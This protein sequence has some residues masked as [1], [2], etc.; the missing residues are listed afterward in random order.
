MYNQEIINIGINLSFRSWT[1]IYIY[2]LYEFMNKIVF[3]PT[4]KKTQTLKGKKKKK[5]KK[6]KNTYSTKNL[7][8][9]AWR[10]WR[11]CLKIRIN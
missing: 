4:I 7:S 10:C 1:L 2:M 8:G 11:I 3:K 6:K 5:K 9:L